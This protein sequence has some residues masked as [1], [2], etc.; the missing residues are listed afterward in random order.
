SNLETL[1]S[2]CST[3]ASNNNNNNNSADSGYGTDTETIVSTM[4]EFHYGAEFTTKMQTNSGVVAPLTVSTI[5]DSSYGSSSESVYNTDTHAS[6]SNTNASIIYN[7]RAISFFNDIAARFFYNNKAASFYNDSAVNVSNCDNAASSLY[8]SSSESIC[9]GEAGSSYGCC[10]NIDEEQMI[11]A[12]AYKLFNSYYN[13]EDECHRR[14]VP[15]GL[16][17]V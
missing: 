13:P 15:Q 9:S 8:S 7:D 3:S 4:D 11:L 14:D 6:A 12:N 1:A 16:L 10:A 2:L 5:N 17:N